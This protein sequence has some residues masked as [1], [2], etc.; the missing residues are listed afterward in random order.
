[1]KKWGK[2][3]F[4]AAIIVALVNYIYFLKNHE[5]IEVH[6]HIPIRKENCDCPIDNNLP[7][8]IID[9]NGQLIEAKPDYIET[10]VN[11]R[12]MNLRD[13]SPKYTA[14]LKLYEPD[15]YTSICEE[16]VPTLETDILINVRGQS[17]LAN[18]KKQYTISLKD[19]NGKENHQ[20]ILGLPKHDKWV[21]NASYGDRSLIRNYLAYKMAGQV[22]EYAPRTRFVEVYLNDDSSAK[23]DFNKHY[24][25][26]YILTEKIERGLNRVNI[27]KNEDKY[28]DISFIIARDKINI[29][30][31]VLQTHWS[32]LEDDYILDEFGNIR[33]RTVIT[34]SY[35][36]PS[37]LSPNH[38]NKIMNYLN[39]LEYTL[40]SNDFND[41]RNGYRRYIDV[42]S[43][44]NFAMINEIFKNI[45]GGDVSTYFYKD[46]GGLMMAGP[47]WD[48]DL[49]LGNTLYEHANDPTGFRMMNTLWFDRLFQ[50]PYFADRYSK[51]LYPYYRKRI[52]SN[53]DILNMI[54]EAV[55][56]L[57]PSINRNIDRWYV[58]Y[59]GEDYLKEIED[60][61]EFLIK[62]LNWMD[63]NIHLVKR[64][65]ENVTD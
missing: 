53:K 24:L 45:D 37:L 25:G 14:K 27:A 36:G 51:I 2:I 65:M 31:S 63:K 20:E 34:I 21:L 17:S 54:D 33:M 11:G 12:V 9:T 4:L 40:K 55:L 7:I 59:T 29:G 48:F 18:P 41:R 62:R 10:S 39:E 16:G 30:D 3:L 46:I 50:D 8:I 44:V 47:V 35:P 60:I 5:P 52:W 57:G 15:E 13:K 22:M 58:G 38:E 49:T 6:K 32:A 23:I 43:F 19:K 61:K 64:L 56:E 42:D 28:N 1:M 26:V